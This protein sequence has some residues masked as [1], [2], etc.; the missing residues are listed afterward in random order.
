MRVLKAGAT[1]PFLRSGRIPIGVSAIQLLEH[2]LADKWATE[3]AQ[4]IA[5]FSALCVFVAHP[6]NNDYVTTE[7]QQI[8]AVNL[9]AQLSAD[10]GNLWDMFNPYGGTAIADT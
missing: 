3:P 5:F 7:A 9:R 2:P 4:L 6:R 8:E 10:R 1:Q